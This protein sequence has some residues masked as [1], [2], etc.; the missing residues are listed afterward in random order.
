[1]TANLIADFTPA[2]NPNLCAI[3]D[4]VNANGPIADNGPIGEAGTI[5]DSRAF[6]DSRAVPATGPTW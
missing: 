2:V 1:M 6:T 4:V 5:A 3:A